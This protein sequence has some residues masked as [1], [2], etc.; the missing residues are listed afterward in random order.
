MKRCRLKTAGVF[1][2]HRVF[3]QSGNEVEV[4]NP[5]VKA[6]GVSAFFVKLD[7]QPQVVGGYRLPQ[8]FF[9]VDN[10]LVVEFEEVLVHG[11]H[12]VGLGA[13]HEVTQ[14]YDVSF[15]DKVLYCRRVDQEVDDG[16]APVFVFLDC[17]ALADDAGQV[18]REVGQYLFVSLFGVKV[19]DAL[20]CLRCGVGMQGED[21]QVAG[22]GKL[23]GVFHA[24]S[25]AD[26]ADADDV[27]RLAHG[28]L[29]G[30]LPVGSVD[31]DFALCE[32]AAARFVDKLY[33]VFDGDDVAGR[34][35]VAVFEHGCHG[36]RFARTGRAGNNQQPP[37]G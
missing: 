18:E 4:V 30:G 16:G 37:R 2:R 6:V 14:T 32:N 34:L 19:E 33:R 25:V 28:V 5:V 26:L 36:G 21:A 17:K 1:R 7:A 3:R 20:E 27:G 22:L 8:C 29:Y 23:H 35:L 10:V 15:E 13:F 12:A 31:A 11:L 9:V 24:F